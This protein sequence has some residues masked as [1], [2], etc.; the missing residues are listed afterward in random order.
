MEDVPNIP[1]DESGHENGMFPEYYFQ[2][3]VPPLTIKTKLFIS[4]RK[5][6]IHTKQNGNI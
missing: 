3:Y 1:F 6:N 2:D 4:H 5:L